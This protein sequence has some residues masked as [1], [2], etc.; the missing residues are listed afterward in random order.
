[1]S[2]EKKYTLKQLK[3]AW[4]AGKHNADPDKHPFVGKWFHSIENGEIKWQG[5]ILSEVTEGKFLIQLYSWIMG[6]PTDQIVVSVEE[7][8]KWHFYATDEDM[9]FAYDKRRK[10]EPGASTSSLLNKK[11]RS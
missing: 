8:V 7:I 10:W 5:Q 1:M 4:A 2:E 3:G 11:R 6:E 9:R